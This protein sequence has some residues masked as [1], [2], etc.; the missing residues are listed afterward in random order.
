MRFL[1][2]TNTCI[3]IIKQKP[4]KVLER[5]QT[6]DISDVGISSIT[7]AE[8]EYGVYKSQRKEQNQAALSQFLIPLEVIPFDE[9]AT[10]AYGKI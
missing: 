6:I 5:F 10:Q 7:V 4:P 9:R 8:L 3:Y 1:L 2:Y